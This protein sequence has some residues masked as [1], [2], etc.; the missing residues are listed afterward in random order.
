MTYTQIKREIA[1][2][3]G[4][5][6]SKKYRGIITNSFLQ[7]VG[8]VMLSGDCDPVEYPELYKE[9]A[10]QIESF[11]ARKAIDYPPKMLKLIDI[12][13]RADIFTKEISKEEFERMQVEEAFRPAL[14]EVFWY[15]DSKYIWLIVSFDQELIVPAVFSVYMQNPDDTDWGF[16][17][18]LI[19]DLK[20][21]RNFIYK[22]IDKAVANIA[23]MPMLRPV[24]QGK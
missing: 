14:N 12:R 19:E 10:L 3:L 21:G 4:D 2:R 7:A 18:D 6:D 9:E 22:C 16:N 23:A 13:A 5:N 17:V 1:K 11:M 8:E 24:T 15:Q 20:Y